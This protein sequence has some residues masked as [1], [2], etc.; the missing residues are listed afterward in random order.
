MPRMRD[1]MR[2]ME[3]WA[4]SAEK[5]S[6]SMTRGKL[7]MVSTRAMAL[8]SDEDMAPMA[9]ETTDDTAPMIAPP[10][11]DDANDDAA[12]EPAAAADEVAL[13]P[14]RAPSM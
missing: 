10:A 4:V 7:F 6:D 9:E 1:A 3:P 2:S 12:F 11:N 13:V 14:P 5:P 8:P